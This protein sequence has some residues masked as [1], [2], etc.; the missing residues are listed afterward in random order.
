MASR[1][2][3]SLIPRD[4]SRASVPP[5]S[6]KRKAFLGI[7]RHTFPWRNKIISALR[8]EMKRRVARLEGLEGEGGRGRMTEINFIIRSLNKDAR[9]DN[10]K[11]PVPSGVIRRLVISGAR[12]SAAYLTAPGR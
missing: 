6:G 5:E 12:P 9:G 1:A 7:H 3:K 11:F 10:K 8:A 4:R 2:S